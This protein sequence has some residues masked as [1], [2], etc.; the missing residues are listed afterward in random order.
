MTVPCAF[1]FMPKRETSH[2]PGHSVGHDTRCTRFCHVKIG[3]PNASPMLRQVVASGGSPK[4]S[5]STGA[6]RN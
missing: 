6:S 3:A 1:N 5:A 2:I 4:W